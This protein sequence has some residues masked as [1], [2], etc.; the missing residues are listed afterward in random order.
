ML[1]HSHFHICTSVCVSSLATSF[2]K[3]GKIN[4]PS[5]TGCNNG[6]PCKNFTD[7]CI[8]NATSDIWLL[9]WIHSQMNTVIAGT[10][11]AVQ[12]LVFATKLCNLLTVPIKTV[13][14]VKSSDLNIRLFGALCTQLRADHNILLF[15]MKYLSSRNDICLSHS[16]ITISELVRWKQYQPCHLVF[17]YI[18]NF[19]LLLF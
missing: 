16:A 5:I 13:T 17:I 7:I 3:K 10:H 9:C 19:L 8:D 4:T 18:T 1:L 12:R 14:Y 2:S 15:H 11:C 6:L